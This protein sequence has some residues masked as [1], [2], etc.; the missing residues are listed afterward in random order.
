MKLNKTFFPG[1][2]IFFMGLLYAAPNWAVTVQIG[3]S[4]KTY[5]SSIVSCA[6]NPD[7]GAQAP[8]IEAGL[9]NPKIGASAN[10]SLNGTTIASVTTSNP[11]T[12]VWLADGKN[13]VTITLNKKTAD[14]YVFS[15]QAG[16][17]APP[18]T[19]GNTFSPDGSLEYGSSGKVYATVTPGCALNAKTGMAQPFINLFDTGNYLL[20]VSVN[21]L[22]LTQLSLSHPSTPIFL[23]AGSNVISV[24]NGTLSTDYF[25]REGG[26]GSC[27]LP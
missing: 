19:L 5:T 18:D 2:A 4:G 24:A 22:P 13:T 23:T 3:A 27:A 21:G 10:V 12:N 7:T 25:L 14:S 8:F 11:A 17:C 1:F 6:A 20:N 16:F 9:F 26:D 15:V